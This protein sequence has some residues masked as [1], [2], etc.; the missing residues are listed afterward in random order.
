MS[1]DEFPTFIDPEL[2]GA[3]REKRLRD[4]RARFKFSA[5]IDNERDGELDRITA[6][7][8]RG[9]FTA[10]PRNFEDANEHFTDTLSEQEQHRDRQ[11]NEPVPADYETWKENVRTTDWPRVDTVSEPRVNERGD[12]VVDAVV[13][14]RIAKQ[15][16]ERFMPAGKRGQ[17]SDKSGTIITERDPVSMSYLMFAEGTTEAHEAGHAIDIA[18][19]GDA[20]GRLHDSVLD[21]P[22]LREQA[23]DLSLR[24]RGSFDLW[25]DRETEKEL[26]A[27][28]LSSMLLEPR[29]AEREAPELVDAV[30]QEVQ[31]DIGVELD[32]LRDWPENPL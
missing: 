14:E 29:A 15:R 8:P 1:G 21:D 22:E 12:A 7:S 13:D 28:T 5:G 25:A 32:S 11:T 2:E 30:E 17:V 3:Q 27:D 19:G 6:D 20:D 23:E 4:R 18:A 24:M 9:P 26:M 16:R 31:E 10:R